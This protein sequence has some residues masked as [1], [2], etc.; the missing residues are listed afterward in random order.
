[1]QGPKSGNIT[2]HAGAVS[3]SQR[4]QARGHRG[5]TL[6]LTGLSGSG[7]STLAAAVEQALMQRGCVA[8]VLDGD[9]LRYGLNRD[10]GFTPTERREN[11]RRIGEVAKLFTDAGVLV[12]C[13]FISPYRQDRDE[14]R[15]NMSPGDFLEIYVNASLAACEERDPKGLYKK[16]R[17]GGITDMT[18]IGSPYEPPERPELLV[19]SEQQSAQESVAQILGFLEKTGYIKART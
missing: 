12:L 3:R 9:N 5:A 7:K 15:A 13:A 4:E 14:V 2:W 10:L 16:A 11:I 18:G 1:M 8:Y 17:V 19:D 6:W